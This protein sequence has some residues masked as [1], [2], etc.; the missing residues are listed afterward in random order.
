MKMIEL[1]S[2]PETARRMLRGGCG[3]AICWLG[4]VLY[5]LPLHKWRA[6]VPLTLN[7]STLLNIAVRPVSGPCEVSHVGA[8]FS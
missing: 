2:D 5:A 6:F 4:V 1:G 8:M 3:P 7:P